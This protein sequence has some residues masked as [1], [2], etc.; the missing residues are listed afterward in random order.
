MESSVAYAGAF[1][2]LLG[3]VLFPILWAVPESLITAELATCYPEASGCVAWVAE[4]FGDDVGLL[5]G[6]LTWLSGVTDN[7]L[8]PVLFIQ[9]LISDT[10]SLADNFEQGSLTRWA[11][12]ASLTLLLSY[13][14][15]RGLE[16]V[17]NFNVAICIISIVPFII[18]SV[19]CIPHIDTAKW[20]VIPEGAYYGMAS[21]K[22]GDFMNILFWNLNYWDHAASVTGEVDVPGKTFPRAS[23]YAVLLVTLGYLHPLLATL[24]V[25]DD[26]PSEWD[27]GY[28][29]IIAKQVSGRWLSLWIVLASGLAN[30]GLY[31]AEMTAD[32]FQLLGMAER[33][34][35]P[36]IFAKRSPYGT[37]TFAILVSS[38][39]IAFFSFFDF[40][41]LV[42]MVNF[43]YI[44]SLIMEFAAF[45][46]LRVSHGDIH[47]PFKIP[48]GT[49]GCVLMLTPATIFLLVMIALASAKTWAV[50]GGMIVSGALVH[51]L[52]KL[53]KN[54]GFCDFVVEGEDSDYS[55]L[56]PGPPLS[57]SCSSTS[58]SAKWAKLDDNSPSNSGYNSDDDNGRDNVRH[59]AIDSGKFVLGKPPTGRAVAAAHLGGE[60]GKQI[61][62][63]WDGKEHGMGELATSSSSSKKGAAVR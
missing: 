22:W 23:F 11:F 56:L 41:E 50:C 2:T 40:T 49:V 35:I 53:A 5:N 62:N 61:G 18:L 48:L 38:V 19:A 26:P 14:N 63:S 7:S 6:Y 59:S 15:Y 43:L 16:I 54:K 34:L 42:E 27:D 25:S 44:F 12:I 55:D 1:Y 60:V 46:K 45:I 47:R 52:M 51:L 17:G 8:Y 21:I 20:F 3:F 4:A 9:Y 57:S 10:P 30:L 32:T 39:I 29:E 13:L 31:Q 36:K 33:G 58:S 28:S 24:G 37:P